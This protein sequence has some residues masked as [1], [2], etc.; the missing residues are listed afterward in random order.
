MKSKFQEAEV[1]TNLGAKYSREESYSEEE[2]QKST[3]MFL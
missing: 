3:K 2:F 1:F